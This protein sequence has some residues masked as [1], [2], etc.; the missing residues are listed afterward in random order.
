MKYTY[1]VEVK[2]KKET[3]SLDAPAQKGDRINLGD[4]SFIVQG[5]THSLRQSIGGKGVWDEG[6]MVLN[7]GS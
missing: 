4:R 2:G 3:L 1:Q 6:V 5:I 7:L